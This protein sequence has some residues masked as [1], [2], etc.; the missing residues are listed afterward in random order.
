MKI[1]KVFMGNPSNKKGQFN[2]IME[3]T[4]HLM[5]VEPGVECFMIRMRYGWFLRLLKGWIKIPPRDQVTEVDGVEFTNLWVTLGVF[6]YLFTHKLHRKP[7]KGESQ[8]KRYASL[9]SKFDL[10]SVHGYESISLALEVKNKYKIPFVSTWHGSDINYTPFYSKANRGKARLYLE[11]ASHNFFVSKRLLDTASIITRKAK[12]SVLYTGPSE[13]FYAYPSER[14]K[15]LRKKYD[16]GCNRII[17]FVGNFVPVKNVMILPEVFKE[18]QGRLNDVAFVLVGDGSL[19]SALKVKILDYNIS[20][21]RFFGKLSPH[22]IPDILNCM[23]VLLLPSLNEGLPRITLEAQACGVYVVGS[24][25]GG[26][27]ESIGE[28]YCFDLDGDFVANVAEKTIALLGDNN[29]KLG[30]PEKFSWDQAVLHE[31]KVHADAVCKD[32]GPINNNQCK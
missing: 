14:K 32:H 13:N 17:G 28:E 19:E 10:L 25:R 8:L 16:L 12:K 18:I 3:R 7:G 9:F 15:E 2:N 30:V 24:S 21:V 27:S 23:D 5:Q 26:I 31:V 1:A 11:S 4:R 6:D 29:K 22:E 20:R